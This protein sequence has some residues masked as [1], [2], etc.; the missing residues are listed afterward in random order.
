MT[1]NL[2]YV[3]ALPHGGAADPVAL[4]NALEKR[5]PYSLADAEDS[6]NIVTTDPSSGVTVLELAFKGQLFSFDSTDTTTPHDGVTCLVSAEGN[7]YKLAGLQVA[8]YSVISN[9]V[10]A[11]PLTPTVG[12]TYLLPAAPTGTNWASHGKQIAIFTARGWTFATPPT[13]WLIYVISVTGYFHKDET[14]AWI[15]GLGSFPYSA[16]SIVPS[17]LLGGGDKVRWIIQ[18]QTTN[19]PPAVSNGIAYIIGPAPT[20]AWAGFAGSIAH[21]EGGAWVI[22]QPRAGWRAYDV[23]LAGDQLFTG[24]QWISSTGNWLLTVTEYTT[25]QTWIK[26]ARLFQIRVYLKAAGGGG[27]GAGVGGNGQTTSFGSHVSATG[28]GAAPNNSN[29]GGPGNGVGGDFN[30]LGSDF[31]AN[32]TAFGLG[33]PNASAGQGGEGGEASIVLQASALGASESITIGLGGTAGAS[34][35]SPGQ[36]GHMVIEAYT[37][38]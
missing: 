22:Y 15:Q 30:R 36:A 35:G 32:R 34:G 38:D 11:E 17:A 23:S 21:G 16:A 3:P 31:Y 37:N 8:P 25:S 4:R 6:R 13:G 14:G 29:S 26:P 18:N 9:S 2:D 10:T 33:G 1:T 24:T 28:G 19:A 5:A 20:G 27:A 7:R 12:D